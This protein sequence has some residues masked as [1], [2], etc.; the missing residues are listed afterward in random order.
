MNCPKCGCE[1]DDG[2]ETCLGCMASLRFARRPG[3]V[4]GFNS[5]FLAKLWEDQARAIRSNAARFLNPRGQVRA[6][7]QAMQLDA[8]AEELRKWAVMLDAPNDQSSATDGAAGAQPEAHTVSGNDPD[9][10]PSKPLLI[11]SDHDPVRCDEMSESDCETLSVGVPGTCCVCAGHD[12]EAAKEERRK[13][14][15]PISP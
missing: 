6:E 2:S 10:M 9:P 4:R 1:Y 12:C 11:D 15:A 8:C 7:A 5:E 13:H 3:L 14:P